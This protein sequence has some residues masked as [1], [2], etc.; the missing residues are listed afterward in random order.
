MKK[1]LRFPE[2]PTYISFHL[3][4]SNRKIVNTIVIALIHNEISN[5]RPLPFG[6]CSPNFIS[7]GTFQD[8][9]CAAACCLDGCYVGGCYPSLLL[10]SND[11]KNLSDKG[12]EGGGAGGGARGDPR[13]RRSLLLVWALSSK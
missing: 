5:I 7:R 2:K 6:Q 3:I 11:G 10:A 9:I 1:E 8:F 13:V 12:F 4:F